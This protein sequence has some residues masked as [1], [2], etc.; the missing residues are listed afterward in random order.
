MNIIIFGAKS[1]IIS[2]EKTM[3]KLE[4]VK[5]IRIHNSRHFPAKINR[6]H[7]KMSLEEKV[8]KK[9]KNINLNEQLPFPRK[10]NNN[11]KISLEEK[12]ILDD[13]LKEHFLKDEK[14]KFDLDNKYRE[15]Y[16]N[17]P[18]IRIKGLTRLATREDVMELLLEYGTTVKYHR[19]CDSLCYFVINSDSDVQNMIYNLNGRYLDGEKLRITEV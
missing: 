4:D 7:K 15:L 19:E 10:T 5:K 14:Y 17:F 8:N 18:V 11:K 2:D 3:I 1:V 16:P 9:A 6:Q 12:R 13:D